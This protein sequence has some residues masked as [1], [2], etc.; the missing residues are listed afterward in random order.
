MAM[1]WELAQAFYSR[2]DF[3]SARRLA[4]LVAQDDLSDLRSRSLLAQLSLRA[5]DDAETARW[6]QEV[7][8]I[9][10][11]QGMNW[12]FLEAS[13]L[14]ERARHGD[15]SGLAQA[16]QRLV[17]ADRRRPRWGRLARL[18]GDLDEAEGKSEQAQERY[19]QAVEYGE[20][21][22]DF[23]E[24]VARGLAARGR[25]ASA[26][27]VI[28]KLE[29]DVKLSGRLA[30]L[31]AEISLA[32]R[33]LERAAN[34]ALHAAGASRDYRERIWLA[35]LLDEAGRAEDAGRILRA[36][37]EAN[38]RTPDARVAL[39]RHLV[40][41]G[42]RELARLALEEARTSLSTEQVPLALAGCF[43]ALG[44]MP[45][46]ERNY[47]QAAAESPEDFAVRG[48][49]AKFYLRTGARDNGEKQLRQLLTPS[50]M[51]P[52]GPTAWARRQL[53]ILLIARQGAGSRTEA[54][55]LLN[56]NLHSPL[57]TVEDQRARARVLAADPNSRQE[58]LKLLEESRS[59]RALP[60]DD[61][62]LL[63]Q[64]EESLG[65]RMK[66]REEL[67][68]LLAH[69]NQNAGYVAD[70]V[71]TLI[72]WGESEEAARWLSQ[73]EKLEPSAQRTRAIREE[74]ARSRATARAP[75]R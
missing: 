38:K 36:T 33:D 32:L 29:A 50:M 27:R 46:A 45:E 30:R 28:K 14:L 7:R 19:L 12:C 63:A 18:E 22:P 60:A 74:L 59:L 56:A 31:G 34:L 8:S 73:L 67:L 47:L 23:V 6:V 3:K 41:I 65:Q 10:G 35:T 72:R 1:K 25:L 75:A 42:H 49:V 5:A 57:A 44:D 11:E 61:R 17:E 52:P 68:D 15:R 9:E 53:A 2:G 20:R 69:E 37:V 4:S 51:T 26:D 55:A 71:R 43:E 39:V 66:A 24:R 62:L 54:M 48:Q 70:Y 21:D 13:S 16:R 64:L 40:R 58:A